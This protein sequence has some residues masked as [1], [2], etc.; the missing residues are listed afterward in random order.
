[1]S[2]RNQHGRQEIIFSRG[3]NGSHHG[4]DWKD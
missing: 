4:N 1:L 2:F 3:R